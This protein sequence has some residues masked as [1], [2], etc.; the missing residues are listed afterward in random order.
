MKAAFV[1]ASCLACTSAFVPAPLARSRGV[2][3]MA[4]DDDNSKAIPFDKRPANLDGTMP[5][6][7]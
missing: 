5:G 3:R 4:A 6:K 7:S 2:A 1:L